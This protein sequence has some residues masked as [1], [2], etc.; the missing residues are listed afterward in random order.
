MF[1]GVWVGG[2]GRG[3]SG[4]D[5]QVYHIFEWDWLV[6]GISGLKAYPTVPLYVDSIEC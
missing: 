6:N 2:A 4:G 5:L 3:G 1:I